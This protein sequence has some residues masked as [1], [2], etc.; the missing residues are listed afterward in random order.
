M[1]CNA[2]V[3]VCA[4]ESPLD[5]ALP[6]AEAHD[7]SENE[8]GSNARADADCQEPAEG[9]LALLQQWLR[10]AAAGAVVRGVRHRAGRRATHK[11]LP[12]SH[13]G[14]LPQAASH[15]AAAPGLGAA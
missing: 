10:Q 15:L 12:A 5:Q 4:T 13:P 14:P 9:C 6:A 8:D 1:S 11:R 3:G 2:E 7:P